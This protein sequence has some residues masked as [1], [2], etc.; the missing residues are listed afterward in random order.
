M[1]SADGTTRLTDA[2]RGVLL[3]LLLGDALAAAGANVPGGAALL[4]S[5]CAAQ[6]TCFTVEG[7]IRASVRH[8]ARGISHPPSVVW[9]ALVR[10]AHIQG[11]DAPDARKRMAYQAHNG[12]P[13]GWLV[14]VPV[15][16]ERRGSA[17]ATVAALQAGRMGTREHWVNDSLGYHGLVRALPVALMNGEAARVFEMAADIAA[18]THGAPSGL[19]SPADGAL[20]LRTLL[21]SDDAV[22]GLRWAV[23]EIARVDEGSHHLDLYTDAIESARRRPGDPRL[24]RQHGHDRSAIAAVR[25]AV[26]VVAS[27]PGRDQIA[28]ALSFAAAAPG[29]GVATTAGAFLGGLHGASALPVGLVSRLELAWVGDTLA[30]DLVTELS[31]SPSGHETL[32]ESEPGVLSMGWQEGPDPHW[33]TRYPGW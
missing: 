5:T 25:G 8:A 21:D 27:F 3:G 28:D 16:A 1:T 14:Q 24:L 18:L 15:L 7:M 29:G 32:I 26:Y 22:A 4:R 9:H 13:D 19:I 2:S 20:I 12:W 31:T 23:D 30:R 6:L 11:I 10:W 33:A 17:P